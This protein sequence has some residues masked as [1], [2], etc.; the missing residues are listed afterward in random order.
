LVTSL[1]ATTAHLLI[2]TLKVPDGANCF[3]KAG[4]ICQVHS[5]MAYQ[6]QA[7][8]SFVSYIRRLGAV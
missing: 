2:E 4:Y 7:H 5:D 6:L 8:P 1:T 3:C